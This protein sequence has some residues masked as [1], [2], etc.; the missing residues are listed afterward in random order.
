MANLQ[1]DESPEVVE[2]E[3]EGQTGDLSRDSSSLS[4]HHDPNHDIENQSPSL[5][6][7]DN[8][9]AYSVIANAPVEQSVE[10]TRTCTRVNLRNMVRVITR[11][12]TKSS[13][14]PGPPPDGGLAAWTQVAMGHLVIMNTWSVTP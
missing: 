9:E 3:K 14:N 10:I 7:M 12:S 8:I 5:I 4:S 11:T 6:A 13:W 2:L 1:Q